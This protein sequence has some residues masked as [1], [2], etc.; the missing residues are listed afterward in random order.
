MRYIQNLMDIFL[1]PDI[2]LPLVWTANRII[3]GNVSFFSW[4]RPI[5]DDEINL[6]V[7]NQ[8]NK[9]FIPVYS[10]SEMKFIFILVNSL[11]R[12]QCRPFTKADPHLFHKQC[13]EKTGCPHCQCTDKPMTVLLKLSMDRVPMSLLQSVSKMSFIKNKK[14]TKAQWCKF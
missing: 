10:R 2:I 13:F 11:F 7:F 5:Y 4:S 12:F 6:Y 8:P 3:L 14:T 9:R 1:S